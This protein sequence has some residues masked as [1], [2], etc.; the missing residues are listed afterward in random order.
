MPAAGDVVVV[1]G[2]LGKHVRCNVGRA[3]VV[4][5]VK[6]NAQ[7][8]VKDKGEYDFPGAYKLLRILDLSGPYPV[9]I[10]VI[11]R[12]EG[13]CARVLYAYVD[14]GILLVTQRKIGGPRRDAR[15]VR[16]FQ[17]PSLSGEKFPLAPFQVQPVETQ[18][19]SMTV[20]GH[21]HVGRI[22]SVEVEFDVAGDVVLTE[23]GM[24]LYVEPGI[25]S[26]GA[27]LGEMAL[28]RVAVRN[29]IEV[30]R[31]HV[32]G[33]G[34]AENVLKVHKPAGRELRRAN[35]ER[36]RRFFFVLVLSIGGGRGGGRGSH[37]SGP[38]PPR[39]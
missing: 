30:G 14:A 3:G 33:I 23:L 37:G 39:R 11:C 19:I 34:A 25:L 28:Y 26:S 18:A 8:R 9:F 24:G 15:P 21:K 35:A 6:L 5:R 12:T 2:N 13:G 38:P 29:G 22:V 36:Q 10:E 27:V 31:T 32:A 16:R 17:A 20:R 1:V 7:G 4:S